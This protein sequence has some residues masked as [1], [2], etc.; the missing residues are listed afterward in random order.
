MLNLW[1]KVWYLLATEF[2][3]YRYRW[4]ILEKPSRSFSISSKDGHHYNYDRVGKELVGMDPEPSEENDLIALC[5][6]CYIGLHA[7]GKI[8]G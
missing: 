4:R 1:S 3:S 6:E 5:R 7:K 8:T 2:F